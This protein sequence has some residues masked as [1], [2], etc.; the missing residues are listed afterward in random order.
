LRL[1]DAQMKVDDGDLREVLGD[2]HTHEDGEEQRLG[3]NGH[4]RS[5][6]D[7]LQG[8]RRRSTMAALALIGRLRLVFLDE[9][10]EVDETQR[11]PS[12]AVLDDDHGDNVMVVP[13]DACSEEEKRA[14]NETEKE[15][16][17]RRQ[18]EGVARNR[19]AGEALGL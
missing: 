9:E 12:V 7:N 13:S 1:D 19:V 18:Q 14:S 5:G 17:R 8:R 4:A 2:G 11:F 10:E 3:G 6:E 16:E 15:E